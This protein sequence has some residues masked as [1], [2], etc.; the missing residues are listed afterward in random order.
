MGQCDFSLISYSLKL[1][2]H[3]EATRRFIETIHQA[4]DQGLVEP[5]CEEGHVLKD[6]YNFDTLVFLLQAIEQDCSR[7]TKVNL[8]LELNLY[9]YEIDRMIRHLARQYHTHII[10]GTDGIYRIVDWGKLSKRLI[11]SFSDW[12][13]D[14]LYA[15]A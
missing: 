2:S 6:E 9:V 7:P 8:A 10:E 14:K 11:L 1:V 4:V 15:A 13:T 3:S 12:E 5:V